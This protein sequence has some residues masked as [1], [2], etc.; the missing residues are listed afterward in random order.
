MLYP[1]NV[2]LSESD[3][4][5]AWSTTKPRNEFKPLRHQLQAIEKKA[6]DAAKDIVPFTFEAFEKKLYRKAGDGAEVF[7]QYKI[8]IDKL[9]ELKQFGTASNYE[10][11]LKSLKNFIVF[12]KGKEPKQLL[13]PEITPDWLKRYEAY[14][15]D[16]LKRTRTTVSMYVRVV[17]TIFNNAIAEKEIDPEIYP[18]G[19]RKYEVPSVK[20]VKKALDKSQLKLLYD[21]KPLTIEQEKAKAFWFF[22]YACNGMNI[23][24]IAFLR[25][26]NLEEDKL[27]F[28][29]AKTIN[30]SKAD[31]KQ[32][33]AYLNDFTNS[34]IN[35]YGNKSKKPKDFIFPILSEDNTDEVNHTK[36]KNF[37]RFINQ[38]LKKLA[39][40]N[41]VPDT[42]ST[43]WARH[44]F[45]TNAIRNGA[46]M[47]FVSEALSHSNMKTTQGY[48]AGFED[49]DKKELMKR[50]ME[51]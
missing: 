11:S 21:A 1:I 37:T 17:R 24:D 25:W 33:T 34:V 4:M 7:Y 39:I 28:F 2:D 36:V 26:E 12:T 15:I 35:K 32:V 22:S 44:S 16:T 42:V 14:M 20:K 23:K 27:Y 30:T 47:E 19:K 13:L 38:N 3:F 10:L 29:R 49:G 45:A 48:F 31:L 18:F 8:A 5:S 50:I 43:Y 9:K 41:G 40:A 46:S 51:F 6:A